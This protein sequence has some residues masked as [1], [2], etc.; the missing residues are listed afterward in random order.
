M[1]QPKGNRREIQ[2]AETRILI[3]NSARTLFETLPY[4]RVT[5]RDL[6]IHAGIGLGTIYKHFPNKLSMLAAAFSDDLKSLYRDA[7]ATVPKD[8]SF[9]NQFLHISKHFYGYYTTHYN[10]S[11]TYLSRVFFFDRE[12][13]DQII[14]FDDAYLEKISELIQAA[15]ARGEISASKN[16]RAL[17]LTLMS[18][19][20][21]VLTNGFLRGKMKDPD[22]MITLLETLVEQTLL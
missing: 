20:L 11:W 12:W 16:S 9:R 15:Q 4:A 17:A 3:L 21:F 13:L 1:K 7:M 10:L 14:A 5:M 8:Q 19:Y 6:A 18:N 22:Q 2:K